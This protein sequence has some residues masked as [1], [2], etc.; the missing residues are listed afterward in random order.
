MLERYSFVFRRPSMFVASL[1]E[2]RGLIRDA[3][4]ERMW[5]FKYFP[6]LA[7]FSASVQIRSVH[8]D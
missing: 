8:S 2:P 3:R 1:I 6:S 7:I 4:G 5:D